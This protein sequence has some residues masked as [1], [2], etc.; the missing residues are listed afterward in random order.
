M[1]D[2][3]QDDVVIHL[4]QDMIR[5]LK[6]L[7]GRLAEKYSVLA[8][9]RLSKNEKQERIDGEIDPTVAGLRSAVSALNDQI[10]DIPPQKISITPH[11]PQLPQLTRDFSTV[12]SSVGSDDMHVDDMEIDEQHISGL[13]LAAGFARISQSDAVSDD[14][15]Q[16]YTLER[17]ES[18]YYEIWDSEKD[19][20]GSDGVS[21]LGAAEYE[22][23][24]FQFTMSEVPRE[25]R[26][27]APIQSQPQ[28]LHS[29]GPQTYS[30]LDGV[31][32]TEGVQGGSAVSSQVSSGAD[33]DE[34]DINKSIT[35]S[36]ES[37]TSLLGSVDAD[38][39]IISD[40]EDDDVDGGNVENEHDIIQIGD[41]IIDL[42]PIFS[43]DDLV[44]TVWSSQIQPSP[45]Q[46]L[47]LETD[48]ETYPWTDEV[49]SKLRRV[50]KLNSF[51]NNQLKAI[52]STLSGKDVF[53]LM[54]TGGGKS[55]CYQLPAIVQSGRTKGTTIVISP[56]VSLMQDQVDHL[57]ELN[58]KA[59]NL[60]SRLNEKQKG[61]VFQLLVNGDLDLLYISPEMVKASKKFQTVLA[62][63][64][65]TGNLARVVVDEAHCVSSWGHDFRPDYKQLD[66]FKNNFP[67]IPIM[68]LTATAN[69][70]VISDIITNLKLSR[71]DTT[72]LRQS[73]NRDNLFYQIMPKGTNTTSLTDMIKNYIT[74]YFPSQT[75]IIYCHS[76]KSCEELSESLSKLRISSSAYHAGMSANERIRVQ[77]SWQMNKIQV[78]CATV[79]F[80]MGI[81]KPDVRFVMHY[82]IPRSLESYYQ[83]T[84]RAGRD[85]K[86]SYCITFY[87]FKDVRKLQKMIQIDKSLSKESKTV[88]LNKLQQVMTY[89]ENQFECRRN[90]ILNYFDEQFDSTFCYKNCDNCVKK[91]LDVD[92]TN[93]DEIQ[94][95]DIT[96]TALHIVKLVGSLDM[97]RV[98]VI[99]CQEIFR[100]S[101]SAKFVQAGYTSLA[102]HGSGKSWS[103]TD[104]ERIFFQLI[105][106]KIL[107][108]YSV[109]N[110]CGYAS[111]YVRV[112]PE[113]RKLKNGQLT[114]N[115]KFNIPTKKGKQ[116][117]F[118]EIVLEK[119]HFA[120]ILDSRKSKGVTQPVRP[121]EP[122]NRTNKNATIVTTFEGEDSV[123]YERDLDIIKQLKEQQCATESSSSRS[124]GS[125]KAYKP[126]KR[127]GR[128]FRRRRGGRKSN[129]AG[130]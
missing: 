25:N 130:S 105:T 57:L 32:S 65:R 15:S 72:I 118:D 103:K 33:Y 68:A 30:I 21:I 43:D 76:K 8:S 81:D 27:S 84:G 53:V 123:L 73:F 55:L 91:L 102:E 61:F 45:D 46:N 48:Q 26:D 114:I 117:K 40:D 2:E 34:D 128:G 9:T 12:S 90:L 60:N 11:S 74:T 38:H 17:D 101:K 126:R 16:E 97:E 75:G 107:Q 64:Y 96:D 88:H 39:I 115:M 108:E 71:T 113:A 69:K 5:K 4:Q 50:F 51:R 24:A 1:D 18:R 67:D 109:M 54:P 10:T 44:P 85:G 120:K 86:Y 56:L 99:N 122:I 95:Q 29:Y 3:Q 92:G 14:S 125:R 63:L 80:G 83:E 36:L 110:K 35:S 98:T 104:V 28:Q 62:S 70:Y 112:G 37:P 59:I 124:G 22:D 79:A 82:T 87:S 52:N 6:E 93:A 41:D 7:S 20:E 111:S 89:C 19:G 42:D 78:I 119:P 94:E 116:S 100:G 121:G 129:R 49:Y 47:E 66:Y 77:K 106:M 31:A 23:E 127:K 58:I 13:A